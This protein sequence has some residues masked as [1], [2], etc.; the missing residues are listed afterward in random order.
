VFSLQSHRYGLVGT[1]YPVVL[2]LH[3][4]L[5]A[6]LDTSKSKNQQYKFKTKRNSQ[7]ETSEKV[8]TF[9]EPF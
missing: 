3:Y 5:M 1:F 9:K 6:F 7:M 4:L 8:I 2:H